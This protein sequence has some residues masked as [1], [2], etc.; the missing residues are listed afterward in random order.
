MMKKIKSRTTHTQ[1]ITVRQNQLFNLHVNIQSVKKNP[2]IWIRWILL[3][4]LCVLSQRR[5]EGNSSR[6]KGSA[7]V[8]P[9]ECFVFRSSYQSNQQKITAPWKKRWQNSPFI[10]LKYS[11]SL[12]Q[13]FLS[14]KWL[15]MFLLFMVFLIWWILDFSSISITTSVTDDSFT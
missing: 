4:R 7:G 5:T 10:V 13:N 1:T 8:K 6:V 15:P 11:S 3:L 12:S 9:P 2:G 14:Q